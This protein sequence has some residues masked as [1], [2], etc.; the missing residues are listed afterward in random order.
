MGDIC[1]YISDVE[2]VRVVFVTSLSVSICLFVVICVS[3]GLERLDE[4]SWQ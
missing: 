4:R 2:C 1:N 3:R